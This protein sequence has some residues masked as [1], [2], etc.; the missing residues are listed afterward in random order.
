MQ[1]QGRASAGSLLLNTIA[2]A[3]TSGKVKKQRATEQEELAGIMNSGDRAAVVKALGQSSNPKYQQLALSH[4]LQM[5]KE[6][7][8]PF[9]G[10]A[11]GSLMYTAYTQPGTKE[12][13]L[14][15]QQMKAP[16][17]VR[18]QT[19]GNITEITPS[20]P[21]ILVQMYE[22]KPGAGNQGGVMPGATPGAAPVPGADGFEQLSTNVRVQEGYGKPATEAE[23]KSIG[24]TN[25]MFDSEAIYDDLISQ[26]FDPST[27]ETAFFEGM[28]SITP[29][30]IS[31]SALPQ[32]VKRYMG[33]KTDFITA[34]LR[35]ESGAAIS[36][37]EFETEN[38]KYFPQ[39]GD[40]DKVL[41]DK[42][43][44]RMNALRSMGKAGGQRFKKDFPD[45]YSALYDKAPGGAAKNTAPAGALD[46]LKKNNTPAVRKQF[47]AKYGYLP[48]GM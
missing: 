9:G 42:K 20:I 46:Y 47:Q 43:Q 1:Q 10:G 44:R 31:G 6:A 35:K 26:G 40:G 5:P 3:I 37:P 36:I 27:T 14:A 7:K 18:D 16:K 13:M 38:K 23:S 2:Q 34:V 15:Y 24:F 8:N 33:A 19:T 12:G 32:D 48:E 28:D 22:P 45:V 11:Q 4:M 21:D 39:P 25:R 30:I 17:T 29:D 41:A